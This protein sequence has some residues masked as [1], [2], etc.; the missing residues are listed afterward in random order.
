[1][2]ELIGRTLA[3]A[4]LVLLAVA[5]WLLGLTHNLNVMTT[6]YQ[7]ES[8]A[9]LSYLLLIIATLLLTIKRPRP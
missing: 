7:A 4:A 6:T 2:I 8:L 5:A 9:N 3:S 1:M